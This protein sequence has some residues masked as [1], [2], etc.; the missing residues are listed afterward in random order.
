MNQHAKGA[1]RFWGEKPL[2]K[3][4]LEFFNAVTT[5]APVGDGTIAT[6][7][8]Y[9][10][11]DSWGGYWG[12]STKDVGQV[13]DAL[14]DTVTQIILR[15]NSPGGEVFEGV[16]ILNMLRAHKAKVTAVVDGLA[17]SAASIIAAGCDETVMSPGTQ[18]MIHSPWTFTLGNAADLRKDADRLEGIESSLIEIYQ[19]KAGDADWATLLADETWYTAAET[20]TVGLA[21]RVAVIPDAGETDTVGEEEPEILVVPLGDDD[22][23][24]SARLTRIAAYSR[25]PKPPSSSEPGDP[26]QKEKLSMSDTIKAGLRERLGVTDA[27]ASDETLLAALDEA[28][29]EQADTPTAATLPEGTVAIDSTVLAELQSN[30]RMGAEARAEQDRARRDSIVATALA[31]GRITAASRD[32]WRT[33]LDSNEEGTTNL[34]ASLAK[35]TAVPVEPLGHSDGLTDADDALA[36]AAGWTDTEKGA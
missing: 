4:K 15:V 32:A 11:I 25:T 9:G 21:D 28:L 5:P 7:R 19:A 18:M 35:N 3:S 29:N 14:P 34:L 2:P 26:N 31:E 24:D 33:Q 13:L 1:H 23:L 16:S 20:V 12:I 27:A 17:A 22:D 30:A 6:I 36:A 8:M 10:P